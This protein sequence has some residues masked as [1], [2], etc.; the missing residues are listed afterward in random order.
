MCAVPKKF[1]SSLR[2]ISIKLNVSLD[3]TRISQIVTMVEEWH[4]PVKQ[5]AQHFGITYA[6]V[7]QLCAHFR[8]TG[9]YPLLQKRGRKSREISEELRQEIIEVK[10][11]LN[12]GS[13]SEAKRS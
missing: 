5:V 13:K 3:N 9:E 11:E 1:E 10:H 8:K 12:A 2:P 7:Y 4:H 6:R